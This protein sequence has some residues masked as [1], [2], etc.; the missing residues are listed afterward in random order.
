MRTLYLSY[1]GMTDPLGSSQVIPYLRGLA[2]RG[3]EITILSAEK[4]ERFAR[5]RDAIGA[6]LTQA[7]IDW[8]PIVYHKKPPMLSTVWDVRQMRKRAFELA[9]QKG[10]EL[11]HCRSYVPSLVGLRLKRERGVRFLFDM[12]GFW[13]DERVDGG[14]WD[15][16]K[17]HYQLAY[18]FFKKRE[19]A[20]LNESDRA[21]SLTHAGKTEMGRWNLAPRALERSR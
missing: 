21:V 13:A 7:R 3:H 9:D 16:K 19:S 17:P 12:R 5:S 10:I 15:L 4:P 14:L 18:R 1:D 8:Q 2:S 11:V 6:V 20:F